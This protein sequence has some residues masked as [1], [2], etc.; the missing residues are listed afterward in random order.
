M[1]LSWK[2]SIQAGS[3]R[4]TL[5]SRT[6]F[7]PEECGASRPSSLFFLVLLR[8]DL[9]GVAVAGALSSSAAVCIASIGGVM[10]LWFG[11]LVQLKDRICLRRNF[12]KDG[13]GRRDG[14][15]W[16]VRKRRSYDDA[17]NQDR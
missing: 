9:R 2:R 5:V 14:P 17:F 1:W 11:F 15:N 16:F 6:K 13:G 12:A 10:G 8:V 4:R 3:C 7:F